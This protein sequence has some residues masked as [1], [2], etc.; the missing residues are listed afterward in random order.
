MM[1]NQGG[2]LSG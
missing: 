1:L 2:S